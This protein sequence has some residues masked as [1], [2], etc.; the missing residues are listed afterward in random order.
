MA[1]KEFTGWDQRVK[2]AR[3]KPITF[4]VDGTEVTVSQPTGKTV[5]LLENAGDDVD[6]AVTALFGQDQ[7]K[8]VMDAYD[9]APFNVLPDLITDLM[10]EFG[11]QTGGNPRVT[12]S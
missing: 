12:R 8:V 4:E 10:E 9:D 6:A 11:L 3:R 5:R 7:A 2:D 1:R